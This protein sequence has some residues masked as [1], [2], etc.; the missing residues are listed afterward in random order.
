MLLCHGGLIKTGLVSRNQHLSSYW[1]AAV[2]DYEHG[3][4]N[5][6][7]LIKTAHPLAMRYNDQSPLENHH[8]SAAALLLMQPDCAYISVSANIHCTVLPGMRVYV[9]TLLRSSQHYNVSSLCILMMRLECHAQHTV[10]GVSHPP[11]HPPQHPSQSHSYISHSSK[12]SPLTIHSNSLSY[13]ALEFKLA[14]HLCKMHVLPLL[15][16]HTVR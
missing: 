15:P 7:F 2:H 5:N 3:G 9:L 6:D 14:C 10:T 12:P 8:I 13:Q 1:S 16:R 11:Q 4:L